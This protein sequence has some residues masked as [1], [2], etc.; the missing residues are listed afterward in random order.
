MARLC[1]LEKPA[2]GKRIYQ[3]VEVKQHTKD[4]IR[5]NQRKVKNIFRALNLDYRV[6]YG[7][8]PDGSPNFENRAGVHANWRVASIIGTSSGMR[9]SSKPDLRGNIVTSEILALMFAQLPA[10]DLTFTSITSSPAVRP[11]ASERRLRLPQY[12]GSR[13]RRVGACHRSRTQLMRPAQSA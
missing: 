9:S 7:I 4:Y 12:S 5:N 2:D 10:A 13:S 6:A 1:V 3:F 8:T 11:I